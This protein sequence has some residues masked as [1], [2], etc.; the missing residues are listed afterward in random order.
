L[1]LYN[2]VY[3]HLPPGVSFCIQGIQGNPGQF[4]ATGSPGRSGSQGS[5]GPTGSTGLAG[6]TGS[7]GRAY[8]SL[9]QF[10]AH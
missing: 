6:R 8:C 3:N 9:D 5:G 2:Y 4:G 7:T 10:N 1:K